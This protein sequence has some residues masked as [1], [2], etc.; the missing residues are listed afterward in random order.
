[1]F[2]KCPNYFDIKNAVF[3]LIGNSSPS[4]DMFLGC[5]LSFLL[6]HYWVG[7]LQS[8]STVF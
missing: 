2:V 7:C 4:Q 5:F 6:G 1:M 8:F 3:N